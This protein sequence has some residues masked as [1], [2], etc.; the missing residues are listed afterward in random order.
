MPIIDDTYLCPCGSK[1][2]YADC[3]GL[4]H[5]RKQRAITAEQLM[6]SRFTAYTQRNAEYL[7]ATWTASKRPP[8]ID[9]SK[10]TAEW[11]KLHIVSCKKGGAKDNKGIVEFKAFYRQEGIDYF[12]HE[13]SRFTKSNQDWLY[14]DGI[15]KAAGRVEQN[16]SMA[17]N[18]ACSCGSGKKFKHCCG[19]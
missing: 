11:Q 4:L 13:I 17:R 18:S 15:I 19:R 9:F 3:C 6:R 2:S 8:S 7:L 5:N 1:L 14:L 10:E 12:M 16:A